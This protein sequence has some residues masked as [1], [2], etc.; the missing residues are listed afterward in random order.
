M[1]TVNISAKK[2]FT[3]MMAM[4]MVFLFNACAKKTT[5]V[6]KTETTTVTEAPATTAASL[7]TQARYRS[8]EI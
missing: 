5:A 4:M 2:V 1:T 6:A 3:G 8:K 7:T